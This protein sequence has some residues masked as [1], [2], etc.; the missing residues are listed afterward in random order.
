MNTTM[1]RGRD[2][3][4]MYFAPWYDG[5]TFVTRDF[6]LACVYGSF[7][8]ARWRPWCPDCKTDFI[9]GDCSCCPECGGLP[10]QC[11]DECPIYGNYDQE[12]T[13]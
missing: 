7:P 13:R 2:T 11:A 10:M 9:G 5:H 12:V 4:L 1:D 6:N 3:W 8:P